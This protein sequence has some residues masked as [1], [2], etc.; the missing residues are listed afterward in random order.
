MLH[1]IFPASLSPDSEDGLCA[2]RRP[3]AHSSAPIPAHCRSF[4][5]WKSLTVDER[6]T[7]EQPL[8]FHTEREN[9]LIRRAAFSFKPDPRA[10]PPC[11]RLGG[12][13]CSLSWGFPKAGASGICIFAPLSACQSRSRLIPGMSMKQSHRGKQG[14][15]WDAGWIEEKIETHWKRIVEK[16]TEW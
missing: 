9:S 11:F 5:N 8:S 6:Q 12:Q 4:N 7:G 13:R 3:A 16:V 14:R 15:N 2:R 1:R 10:Q